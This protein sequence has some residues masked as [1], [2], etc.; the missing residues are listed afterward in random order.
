MVKSNFNRSKTAST[1]SQNNQQSKV[2]VSSP[3]DKSTLKNAAKES[4]KGWERGS[5]SPVPNRPIVGN[6]QAEENVILGA[7]RR[8]L[9]DM[10]MGRLFSVRNYEKG[11]T[12]KPAKKTTTAQKVATK[13]AATKKT[14]TAKKLHGRKAITNSDSDTSE[15]ELVPELE[16]E[17]DSE[18]ALGPK[19]QITAPKIIR[20]SVLNLVKYSLKVSDD[21]ASY[22][23]GMEDDDH[24]LEGRALDRDVDKVLSGRVDKKRKAE[25][26]KTREKVE[27][28]RR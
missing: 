28:V 6:P 26:Q 21:V 1:A 9:V 16:S 14:A 24:E 18:S 17:S 19:R 22:M 10:N 3:K 2:Q 7:R 15:S 12:S 20:R 27:A 23:R 13:K 5:H 8:K 4:G 25:K 11:H